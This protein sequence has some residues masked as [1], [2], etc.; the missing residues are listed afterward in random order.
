MSM[1][2]WSTTSIKGK[3]FG[4]MIIFNGNYQVMCI[5]GHCFFLFKVRYANTVQ[6]IP[7]RMLVRDDV[8]AIYCKGRTG[9]NQQP[10]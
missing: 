10:E 5:S 6:T 4:V 3:L 1:S 9:G 7:L 8:S 2:Y